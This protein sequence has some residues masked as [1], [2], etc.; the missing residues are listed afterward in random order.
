MCMHYFAVQTHYNGD[1][2][3]ICVVLFKYTAMA[4]ATLRCLIFV[5]WLDDAVLA[6]P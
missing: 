1:D 6:G 2:D 5:G 3:S 4:T